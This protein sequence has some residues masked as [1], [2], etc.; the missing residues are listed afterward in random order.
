MR[1]PLEACDDGNSTGTDGCSADCK[2]IEQ[3]FVCPTPGQA[4]QSTVVCGDKKLS[5]SETC[6]DG[7]TT[8]GDGCAADCK[9]EA[10]WLCALPG[11][12]CVA[13]AC[14]DGI[15]AGKEQCDDLNSAQPGCSETCQ[16]D[17]GYQ[18]P[19][20]GQ[21][22]TPTTCGDG[23]AEG[24]EQCDDGNNDMGDGCTPFCK[25]EPNCSQGACTSVCGDGLRLAGDL[26]EECE[27]GNTQ[28]GDGCSADCKVE[29]GFTCQ[30]N[31]AVPEDLKLPL[32]L[33]DFSM[34]TPA[35]GQKPLK[36]PDFETYNCG[37]KPGMAQEQLGATGKP[38]LKDAQGCI[39]SAE[40]FASWYAD[41]ADYNATFLQTMTL[42]K[43]NNGTYRFDNSSFFPLDGL[44]FGNQGNNHNFHFTSE[45]RYYFEYKGGEQLDFTG[46]DDVWVFVNRKLAVDLGGLHGAS[47]GSVLLGDT[48][49]NGVLDPDET[50]AATDPRFALTKGQVYE[51]VVF[52]AERHTT[53]S[54]YRLTLGGFVNSTTECQSVCGNG[55][56][57]PNEQCDDGTNDGGY[58]ECGQGCVID[59]FCGDGKVQDP[60]EQCD[61]GANVTPYA[62][63]GEGCAPGCQ[64]PSRCG[65]AK[66]DGLF[67]EQC[68]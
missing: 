56:V 12:A 60:Q 40:S 36:H 4:C 5:G 48:S 47:N 31:T 8:A 34:L 29:A 10:G 13:A 59:Q 38:V 46:D 15:V 51:I 52:Q 1:D 19:T 9:T 64:K 57:T 23:K 2:A 41:S 33:R 14:G 30:A 27:D 25:R 20:P 24:T 18:C 67:G 62:A 63:N 61:D 11:V 65:D 68:D 53:Q 55:I 28:S 37:L 21:P 39:S 66:L 45:V 22:C 17:E 7:N 43:Q 16:L 50:A 32:V 42:A 35:A 54:N 49:G 3:G 6:D 26:N 58:G 44:G